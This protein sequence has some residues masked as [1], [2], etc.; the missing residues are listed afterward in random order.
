MCGPVVGALERVA[1]VGRAVGHGLAEPRLEVAPHVGRRVLVQR[2]RGRRVADEDVR[3]ADADLAQI[4]HGAL[5]L[6][7]D[8]VEA[9]RPRL[10]LH[11]ALDP[12]HPDS[13]RTIVATD[14]TITAAPA[15]IVKVTFSPRISHPRNTAITGFTYA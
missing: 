3:D 11:L 7:R 2:Q 15:R 13:L 10:E 5:D 9:A 12:D 4:G 6:A 1:P 8:E 14:S